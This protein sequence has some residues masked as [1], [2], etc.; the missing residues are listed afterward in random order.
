M[1]GM[2]YLYC[3]NWYLKFRVWRLKQAGRYLINELYFD[4]RT[5]LKYHENVVPI[6]L[7]VNVSYC[8]KKLNVRN[9]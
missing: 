3:I 7:L 8:V 4:L 2:C 5:L 1:V 9:R 6:L